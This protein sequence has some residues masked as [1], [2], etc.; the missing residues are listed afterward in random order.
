MINSFKTYYTY[1]NQKLDNCY[2]EY[3]FWS[4]IYYCYNTINDCLNQHPKFKLISKICIQAY[5]KMLK[6]AMKG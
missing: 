1:Q 3:E 4:I 5:T 2:Y 6:I